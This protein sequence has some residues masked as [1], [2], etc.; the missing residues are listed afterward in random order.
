MKFTIKKHIT[1]FENINEVELAKIDDIFAVLKDD[2]G[3]ILF[4]LINPFVLKDY[5]FDVSSDI[6]ALLEIDENSQIEVYNS[7]VMKEPM[8]E[9]IVNFKEPFLFNFNKNICVQIILENE[10]FE[11]VGEFL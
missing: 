6:K 9:S 5:S 4:S 3:R 2:E 7:I 1:G 10:S 11:K 8:S